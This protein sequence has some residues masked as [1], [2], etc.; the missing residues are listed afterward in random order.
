[1]QEEPIKSPKR[2]WILSIMLFAFSWVIIGDLVS[3]H[4]ELLYGNKIHGFQQPYTKTQKD[5]SKTFK[6]KVKVKDDHSGFKNL[7][8]VKQN[9][10]KAFGFVRRAIFVVEKERFLQ[11]LV[12]G[13]VC[14]RGPPSA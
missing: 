1:M 7:S 13:S 5:S 12:K 14:R 8:L 4:I 9:A 3:F 6:V 11:V 10:L 2:F